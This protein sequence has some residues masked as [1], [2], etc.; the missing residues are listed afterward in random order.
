MA[1]AFKG[2]RE[3]LGKDLHGLIHDTKELLKSTA[4]NVS[5]D[6]AELRKRVEQRLDGIVKGLR[7]K[8]QAAEDVLKDS[9]G[10]T[11]EV[12]RGHPYPAIGISLA[13]GVLLGMLFHRRR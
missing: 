9:L 5:D 1:E 3:K 6:T 10:A 7:Q 8:A 12:I 2:T 4:D 11:D 13:V